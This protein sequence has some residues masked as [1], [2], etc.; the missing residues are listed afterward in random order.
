MLPLVSQFQYLG[1][2]DG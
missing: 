2:W 1:C